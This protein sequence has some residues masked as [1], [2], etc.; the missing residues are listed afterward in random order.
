MYSTSSLKCHMKVNDSVASRSP[1]FVIFFL[2]RDLTMTFRV[3]KFGP[4]WAFF[5]LMIVT[6]IIWLFFFLFFLIPLTLE[7]THYFHNVSVLFWTLFQKRPVE[8]INI[9]NAEVLDDL[10]NKSQD[11]SDVNGKFINSKV[12]LDICNRLYYRSK[13]YN[14]FE[15]LNSVYRP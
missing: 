14:V 6:F 3:L 11:S 13:N 8:P 4:A 10:T 1:F 5:V 7:A 9:W 12:I 15:T 2:I